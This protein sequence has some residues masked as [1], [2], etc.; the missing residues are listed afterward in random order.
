MSSSSIHTYHIQRR[1]VR[2][3]LAL[4]LVIAVIGI[5]LMLFDEQ[6]LDIAHRLGLAPG[7]N[8]ELLADGDEEAVLVV[9]PLGDYSGIGRERYAYQAM[10]IA[11]PSNAGMTLHDIESGATVDVPLVSLDFT[12]AGSDGAHILFRGPSIDDPSGE[13]AVVLQTAANEIDVLPEGQLEPD[14]PGDWQTQTWQKVTGTCDRVSPQMRYIACFNRADAADYLAGD[15]QV[16]VQLY[17]DF[18]FSEPVYRGMGFLPILG[19]AHDDTWLYFQNETGIYRAEIPQSL[20][21][22]QASATPQGAEHNP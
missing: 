22:Q 12:A 4:T 18:E 19:F 1:V 20:R 11:R 9:I 8:A 2:V 17:G 16:D 6:R 3:L 5:P 13:R 14:L 7:E 15:W 21:E 10:Y